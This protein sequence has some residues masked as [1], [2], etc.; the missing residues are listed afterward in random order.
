[1]S[2][3]YLGSKKMRFLPVW[4]SCGFMWLIALIGAFFWSSASPQGQFDGAWEGQTSAGYDIL[5]DVVDD[6][7]TILFYSAHYSCPN[8]PSSDWGHSTRAN[9][10]IESDRFRHQNFEGGGNT[11]EGSSFAALITGR[12][13]SDSKAKGFLSAHAATFTEDKRTQACKYIDSWT[14]EYVGSA[15]FDT[16]APSIDGESVREYSFPLNRYLDLSAFQVGHGSGHPR[17]DW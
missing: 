15:L 10:A 9:A 5:F 12:F 2:K 1:M 11:L 8:G 6:K 7:V 4:K 13:V 17:R 16:F 14:A 3:A